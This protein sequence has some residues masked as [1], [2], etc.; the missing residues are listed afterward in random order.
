MSQVYAEYQ[1]KIYKDGATAN[2]VPTVTTDPRHLEVQ[3]ERALGSRPF[4]YVYGGT[5]MR[6]TVEAN[7]SA[8]NQWKLYV[9]QISF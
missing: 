4:G 7:L 2:L 6:T 9:V 1:T 3:A 8:F 5:G